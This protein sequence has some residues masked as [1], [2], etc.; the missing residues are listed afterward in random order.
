[1]LLIKMIAKTL[2]V[3]FK[4]TLLKVEQCKGTRCVSNHNTYTNPCAISRVEG[5]F[6]NPVL[7]SKHLESR[8]AYRYFNRVVYG[9][10]M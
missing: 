7:Y 8:F 3:K 6:P 4:V 5:N 10:N 2:S 9:T 1:M